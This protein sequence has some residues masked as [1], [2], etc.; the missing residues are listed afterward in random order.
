MFY[1]KSL[2]R[3]ISLAVAFLVV[4]TGIIP[5]YG[6]IAAVNAET[7][8]NQVVA[9]QQFKTS[10]DWYEIDQHLAQAIRNAYNTTEDYAVAELDNWEEE[11]LNQVDNKFLNWYFSYV[12]QK[13]MEFGVPFAWA[14]FKLDSVWKVLRNE[15][16]KNLNAAQIIQHRMIEDFNRKFQ[17]LVFNDEAEKKFK[18]IVENIGRNY[19][20][21]LGINFLQ[22]KYYYKIDDA[23][24]ENHLNSIS[25]LIYNTGTSE[26]TLETDGLNANLFTKIFV[27]TTASISLKIAAN[28][29]G[30]TGSKLVA[31]ATASVIA[32][33]TAQLVDPI[34]IVGFLAW[35]VWDYNRMIAGSKPELR[36]NIADYL[37]E[38]KF[39]ILFSPDNS[40]MTALRSVETEFINIIESQSIY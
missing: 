40:I 38:V 29:A 20:S 16:E 23:E 22:T 19:A 25:Q 13:K 17:E 1:I 9:Q 4:W 24:W 26:S 35:D 31:K 3:F 33:T 12:N 15:N 7:I 10:K 2:Q 28:F 5:V 37:D 8:N 18:R 21:D 11:L 30:K 27:A 34:L 14:V 6:Q 39:S 36:Q 32:K